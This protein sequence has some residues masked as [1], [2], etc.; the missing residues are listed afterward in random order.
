MVNELKRDL[1]FEVE[2]LVNRMYLGYPVNLCDIVD[3]IYY[4][5]SLK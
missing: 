5:K 4:I 1:I 2:Q 3:K